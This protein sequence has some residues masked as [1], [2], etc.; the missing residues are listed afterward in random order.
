ME[1]SDSLL[2]RG[3]MLLLGKNEGKILVDILSGVENI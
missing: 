1:I 3:G 2:D